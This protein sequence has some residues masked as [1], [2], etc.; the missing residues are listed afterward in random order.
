MDVLDKTLKLGS[1]G[2]TNGLDRDK[3]G[4]WICLIF[5]AFMYF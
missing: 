4:K 1:I 3:R 5:Y 2:P